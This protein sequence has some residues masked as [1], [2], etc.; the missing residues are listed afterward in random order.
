MTVRAAKAINKQ[1]ENDL[2]A[3]KK[4]VRQQSL[5]FTKDHERCATAL[6][7]NPSI[8]EVVDGQVSKQNEKLEV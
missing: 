4:E 8:R 6:F 5:S 1:R 3:R 7:E 2:D